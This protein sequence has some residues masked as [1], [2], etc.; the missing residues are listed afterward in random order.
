MRCGF[1]IGKDRSLIAWFS[2]LLNVLKMEAIT[3]LELIYSAVLTIL[4]N[5]LRKPFSRLKKCI[6]SPLIGAVYN[7]SI[8]F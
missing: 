3:I 4:V 7:I 2:I 5:S 1:G 8:L 6:E